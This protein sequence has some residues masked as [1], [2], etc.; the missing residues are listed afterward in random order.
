VRVAV[1]LLLPVALSLAVGGCAAD[2]SQPPQR[3]YGGS[4]AY[5]TGGQS[6]YGAD[7]SYA[8]GS[9]PTGG[10][11]PS[12]DGS[13][14]G[15]PSADGS[16]SAPPSPGGSSSDQPAPDG[17]TSGQPSSDPLNGDGSMPSDQPQASDPSASTCDYATC[18]SG[19]TP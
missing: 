12:A 8:G 2:Q 10:D 7:P 1:R 13:T 18:T 9:T 6:S 5:A 4:P 17:S 16:T 3:P 19:G 14:A 15:Q 11:Q